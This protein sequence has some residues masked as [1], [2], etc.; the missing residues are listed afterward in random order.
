MRGRA[1]GCLS[2]SY[3]PAKGGN[4]QLLP[5]HPWGSAWG[6]RKVGKSCAVPGA[7]Q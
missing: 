2:P 1:Y 3:G 6:W 5:A 4:E 7:H